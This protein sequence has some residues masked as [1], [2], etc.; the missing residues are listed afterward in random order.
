MEK[1]VFCNKVGCEGHANLIVCK[2]NFFLGEHFYYNVIML[3]ENVWMNYFLV[4]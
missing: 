2:Y 3:I 4:T 1:K